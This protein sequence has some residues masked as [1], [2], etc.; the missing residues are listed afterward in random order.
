MSIKSGKTDFLPAYRAAKRVVVKIGSALLADENG[1]LRRKWLTAL[2]EDIAALHARGTQVLIVS[3]GAVAL[4]RTRLGLSDK[5][6]SLSDKQACAAAGQAQLTQA[7]EDVLAPHE[8]YTSQA[9]LTL[10]D[11]E[12]RRRWL[13]A[14][15][16]LETLLTLG[17]IPIVNENDTVAT[18]EIRYGD[19]DRLAARV[20]Q[21]VGADFLLLLSDIDGLYTSDPRRSG[22]ATHIPMIETITEQ[23]IS[24]GGDAN[25]E[26]GVGSGGMATKLV[27]AQIAVAA[28]CHLLI[29]KGDTYRPLSALENGAKASWFKASSDPRAARKQWISGSLSPRGQITIDRGAAKALSDGNSLLAAGVISIEGKFDKGDAVTIC[30][31]SGVILARGLIAYNAKDSLKIMGLNSSDIQKALG[32]TN[33]AALIHRDDLVINDQAFQQ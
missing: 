25:T 8:I 32:Y 27:A 18:N 16:T 15:S 20:A 28:G 29:T 26:S 7:Y 4:G 31:G 17:S 3:S 1:H 19:N 21:M 33:G 6:L 5:N 14:R 10:M 11:T 22:S 12:D 2:G 23:I 30:D 24:M 13:N 9:L